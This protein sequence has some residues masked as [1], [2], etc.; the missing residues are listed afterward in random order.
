VHN[1]ETLLQNADCFVI[2]IIN[3]KIDK[4]IIAATITITTTATRIEMDVAK[5]L[6]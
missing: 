6:D 2:I 1:G 5:L 3:V 4:K